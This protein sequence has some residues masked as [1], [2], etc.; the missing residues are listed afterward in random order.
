MHDSQRFRFN[1]AECLRVSQQAR[2]PFH[3]TAH[4]SMAL[5]WL[6]LARQHEA[7]STPKLT[8]QNRSVTPAAA[9]ITITNC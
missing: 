7:S 4:L 6:L 1:A 5:S 9:S 8:S 2:D 3:R